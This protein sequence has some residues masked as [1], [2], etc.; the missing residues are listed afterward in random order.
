MPDRL[1]LPAAVFLG[2]LG[3]SIIFGWLLWVWHPVVPGP[4]RL[5]KVTFDELPG[6]RQNDPRAALSA[7]LRSCAQR[8]AQNTSDPLGGAGY[9]GNVSDW[10]EVCGAVQAP[11]QSAAQARAIFERWFAP[12]CISAG[13]M[14]DGLFTGYFEPQLSASRTRHGKFQ[15]PVYAPPD[16]LV[17]VDLGAFRPKLRGEQITGRVL[18]NRL[19]PYATRADIDTKGL[20]QA[21]VLF[22]T[23]DPVTAFFLH[24]QGS[25]RVYFDDG[26]LERISYAAQNGQQY[27]PVGRILLARGALTREKVSLQSIRAW[28][29]AHPAAARE[30]MEGNASYVFFKEEVL[31]DPALGA[32]GSEGVPLT[33]NGSIAVDPRLHAFGTPFYLSTTLPNGQLLRSLFIAQDSGG[34]I[35]GPVRGDVYF[36]TGEE[37]ETLAGQMRQSGRLYALLPKPLAGKLATQTDYP[38]DLP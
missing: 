19:V 4:L 28:L 9:A 11:V 29:R 24:I 26:T 8:A 17:N 36:G 30:V 6:W 5:T 33:P 31:G 12:V 35:R 18:G 1:R 21:R 25:G 10:R 20:P 27:T 38:D 32:K 37:A 15:T 34:A 2:L 13:D 7:F 14:K 23:S 16:D 3:L 22:Y